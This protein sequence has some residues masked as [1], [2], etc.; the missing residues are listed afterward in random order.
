MKIVVIGGTGLI[1]SKLVEK[2]REDGHEPLAASPDTGVNT[3]TGD[4]LAEALE[5]AQVVVDVANAPVWD[6][7]AVLDFF[8]TSSRNIL[9][10]EAAAGVKHH[11]TLSVVG[12]DRLPE[13]GY[14]RAKLAQEETAKTGS[15]PYTILRATQFFE[16][17][18]RIADSS[19]D[20][21]TVHL[22]P[23][24]VQPESADDV[25]AALAEVAVSEPVNGIVELAGPEQFRLDE[26]ARRVLSANNDSRPVT[27]DVHARYFGAELADHSLTPGGNAR[28]T[29]TRFEDWL[30]QSMS[31]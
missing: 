16:F 8:Q 13:S 14:L 3:L 22:A 9:A 6:D 20:G 17:I 31:G 30:S 27:P 21:D 11:V 5:G 2:L 24:F 4:G 12:A 26:L 25:A 10:A 15:I 1:G 28:I 29:P 19:V 23:V 7:A 18:G